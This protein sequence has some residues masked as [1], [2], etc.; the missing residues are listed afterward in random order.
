MEQAGSLCFTMKLSE[1]SLP[2]MVPRTQLSRNLWSVSECDRQ[3]GVLERVVPVWNF[4]FSC[5][6]IY[7]HFLSEMYFS[8]FM[9]SSKLSSPSYFCTFRVAQLWVVFLGTI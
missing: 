9:S 5:D 7:N 1:K 8:S 4:E 3:P 2:T 6:F